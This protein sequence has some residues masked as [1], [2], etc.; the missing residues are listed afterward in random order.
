MDKTLWLTFLGHPVDM[1]MVVGM[2]LLYVGCPGAWS[3]GCVDSWCPPPVFPD[4]LA[5]FAGSLRHSPSLQ[6][7]TMELL[8]PGSPAS[9]PC[10]RLLDCCLPP[11]DSAALRHR[12]CSVDHLPPLPSC[13]AGSRDPVASGRHRPAQFSRSLEVVSI[14]I[15]DRY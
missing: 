10:R 15:A 12:E 6:N 1:L 5:T 11:V 7:L 3:G 9:M 2:Q 13:Q 14:K 8:S 4:L